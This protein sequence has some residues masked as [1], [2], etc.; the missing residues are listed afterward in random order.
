MKALVYTGPN[1]VGYTNAP[2]PVPGPGEA[3]VKVEA[4]GICGSDMH[5]YHGQDA[6]RPPPLIL[7]H[8]AAGVVVE[9]P[10]KGR[11]VTVNPLVVDPH[12]EFSRA[13]MPHLSPSRVI[14]SMPSRP[15][16]FAEYVRVPAENLHDIP[17]G[18]TM[19]Q[20]A[21]A[22]P[23]AVCLHAVRHGI[24]MLRTPVHD[25]RAVVLG[26]GAIGFGSALALKM[27]GAGA[28]HL[29]ETHAGRR[30]SAERAGVATYAPGASGE[31]AE[32]S[33]DLIIDAVGAS[34]TRAAA[35]RLARPGAVIVHAGLL[36]GHDGLD[37]RKITL[38]EI[39]FSGT[40]C[41]TPGDFHD[42]VAAMGEG[43]LGALDWF[44]ERPLS[45]GAEAFRDIDA[46]A[47]SLAKIVLKP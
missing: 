18:L 47:V 42:T 44:E 14:I 40:Y 33:I 36:P 28:V 17:A 35:C 31:P 21:L 12:C 15:G 25:A 1:Q 5:A 19:S 8:E 2:D 6:R 4:V 45:A 30:A 13:G 11:R 32:S 7:G 27:L 16:A 23:L 10:G 38:Q 41:Y 46:G 39:V 43:R 34:A 26:G 20:A 29:G 37:I 9:G 22:E 24:A 3:L